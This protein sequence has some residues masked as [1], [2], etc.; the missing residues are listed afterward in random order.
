MGRKNFEKRRVYVSDIHLSTP[1]KNPPSTVLH[2]YGWLSKEERDSFVDFLQYLLEDDGVGEV[3]LLGDTFDDWIF[4]I[5]VVPASIVEILTAPE[6]QTFVNKLRLLSEKKRVV[7][8]PGNHDM[9]ATRDML[10]QDRFFPKMVFGGSA[11]NNS[12]F[13]SSRL[14]AEHGSAHAL[15]CAP[16][17]V[18]NPGSQLPLG[19]FITRLDT[20]KMART[21]SRKK[22]FFTMID[23]LV[24]TLGP[25]TLPQSIFECLIEWA[26]ITEDTPI[27]MPPRGDLSISIT[28]GEVKKKYADLYEQWKHTK[29]PGMAFKAI[30]AEIGYLGDLADNLC[31][32]GDTNIVIFGHSHDSELD[33]DS[34]FVDDRIYANCGAWC[35]EK[36][37]KSFVESQKE[38]TERK[39]YIR[40]KQWLGRGT[41]GKPNI[42]LIGEE[43]VDL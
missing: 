14:L 12:V 38:N 5:D 7:F 37:K 36:K 41:S 39:H 25:Q 23:D 27:L 42:A 9:S 24:E 2:D 30:M 26:G 15:F 33:K 21:R 6:N 32:R 29:G 17:P 1:S 22:H 40:L 3:I 8:M 34:W 31:K 4:P 28:A 43:K 19:Y 35:D 11:F 13:R 20:T 18:N 16:D 10:I